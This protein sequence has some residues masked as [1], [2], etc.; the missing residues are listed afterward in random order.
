[1]P[2]HC[3]EVYL[4]PPYHFEAVLAVYRRFPHPS[5]ELIVNNAYLRT[6]WWNDELVLFDVKDKSTPEKPALQI[7]VAIDQPKLPEALTEHIARIL[8]YE[9]PRSDFWEMVNADAQLREIFAPIYGMPTLSMPNVFETLVN[10]IIEQHISWKNA[11][12]AQHWLVEWGEQAREYNGQV[13]YGYPQAQ[14]LA[15]ADLETLKPLKITHGRINLIIQVAQQVNSGE[16]DLEALATLPHEIAYKELLKI[17][18]I[19]HW[20]A[21]VVLAR[22]LGH[23]T[24]IPHNDVALQAAVNRYFYGSEGRVSADVLRETFEPYGKY[25]GLVGHYTLMRWVLDNY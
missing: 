14:Q 17:K 16:L 22:A 8:G 18:G 7:Q 23:Y 11:R 6:L 3:Y 24:Y 15:E 1:M 25:A 19:G 4:E 9:N 5:T 20:T 2:L 13:Y 10:V 12:Q 21:S